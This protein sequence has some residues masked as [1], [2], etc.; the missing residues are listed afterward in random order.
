MDPRRGARRTMVINETCQDYFAAVA[1]VTRC[2]PS[3]DAEKLRQLVKQ[4]HEKQNTIFIAGNGGGATVADHFAL[5]MSLNILRET[6]YC[7]RAYS[8][9]AGM[10]LSAA[11]ND[12]GYEDMFAIQLS[13]L[14]KEY[15]LFIAVSAS[16]RSKNLAKAVRRANER[17]MRSVAIVG[18][19]G[20]VSHLASLKIELGTDNPALAEDV[21][22]MMLH[23][24]YCSF[25]KKG[26]V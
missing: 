15:D 20:I 1:E 10:M 21:S 17:G 8:L 11:V 24:V 25:M 12:F 23:W 5:G 13:A 18:R 14:G 7:N 9:N 19:Q 4:T 3:E 6:G 2:F 16:G 26:S 22:M